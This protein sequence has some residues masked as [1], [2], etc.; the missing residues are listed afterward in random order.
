MKPF[1]IFNFLKLKEN[2]KNKERL[3]EFEEGK[4]LQVDNNIDNKELF[5]KK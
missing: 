4:I 3:K 2:K 5:K 1:K